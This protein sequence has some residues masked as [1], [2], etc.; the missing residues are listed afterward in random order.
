[1]ATKT[2]VISIVSSQDNTHLFSRVLFHR[3]T[4]FTSVSPQYERISIGVMFSGSCHVQ[5][6]V[7]PRVRRFDVPTWPRVRPRILYQR[8]LC[9]PGQKSH[10]RLCAQLHRL[11][12]RFGIAPH[13]KDVFLPNDS[14]SDANK[15]T[16]SDTLA[17]MAHLHC[18]RRTWVQTQ[19]RIP[20]L[21]RN[22]E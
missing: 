22:R 2:S 20:V 12:T 18:R 8:Q 17:L 19:T 7:F 6:R 1:M 13:L 14:Y 4:I 21:H 3:A 11:V 15:Y 9:R 10:L 16:N 5:V